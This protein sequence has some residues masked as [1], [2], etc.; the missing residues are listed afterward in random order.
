MFNQQSIGLEGLNSIKRTPSEVSGGRKFSILSNSSSPEKERTESPSIKDIAS[1]SEDP[2]EQLEVSTLAG[3][4]RN[5][6]ELRK[7]AED[8]VEEL[9][10]CKWTSLT[11][12]IAPI[13]RNTM[14]ELKAVT[15]L[16]L[17][18]ESF[19]KQPTVFAIQEVFAGISALKNL[20]K[21][22]I[23]QGG[24]VSLTG[25]LPQ[26]CESLK[27]LQYLEVMTL[28]FYNCKLNKVQ[29]KDLMDATKGLYNL[30][31]ITL[32][33][34]FCGLNPELVKIMAEGIKEHKKFTSV[35]LILANNAIRDEGL[36]SLIDSFKELK[37]LSNLF[38]NLSDYGN[39]LTDSSVRSFATLLPE[40]KELR[41]LN[42]SFT[43][44]QITDTA[45]KPIFETFKLMPNLNS[46][47]LDFRSGF[48][49]ITEYSVKALCDSLVKGGTLTSI[50][51]DFRGGQNKISDNAKNNL[52]E[53]CKR[54]KIYS[55]QIIYT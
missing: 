34:R 5:I 23:E 42:L 54:L 7:A 39:K 52:A 44:N 26:L 38:L 49:F 37:D 41:S 36:R 43:G 12:D 48:N 6:D 11:D 33:F 3:E 18:L 47:S 20:K 55:P 17:D 1:F 29:M 4:A 40:L 46:L 27:I 51:L 8:K 25:A 53:M 16:K 21:F 50:N 24:I 28:N 14:I 15:A 9:T 45:A 35:V 30:R 19:R 22:V 10:I 32:D 31:E 2:N 13:V